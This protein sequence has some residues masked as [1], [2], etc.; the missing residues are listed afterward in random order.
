MIRVEEL[1]K[2]YGSITALDR[3][4]LQIPPGVFGLLGPN[5]AGK[6][7]LLGVLAGLV[8]S[9]GTIRIGDLDV[10]RHGTQFRRLVGYVPQQMGCFP[11]MSQRTHRLGTP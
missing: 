10:R 3:L 7:T 8:P 9:G 1:T 2:Q 11:G 5:G 4:N 6:S